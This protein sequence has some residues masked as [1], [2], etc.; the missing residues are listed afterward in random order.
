[1]GLKKFLLA[2]VLAIAL[3]SCGEAEKLGNVNL[4]N[5]KLTT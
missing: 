1:M 5:L 3:L 4:E 2:S